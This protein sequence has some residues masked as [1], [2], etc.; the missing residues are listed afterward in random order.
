MRG[1]FRAEPKFLG[2][3]TSS[4]AMRFSVRIEVPGDVYQFECEVSVGQKQNP[5]RYFPVWMRGV[6]SVRTK[7]PCDISQFE[8]E[9]FVGQDQK[10]WQ[11]PPVEMRGAFR[12]EPKFLARFTSL[13]ARSYSVRTKIPGGVFQFMCDAFFGQDQNSWRYV[14][15]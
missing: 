2:I 9:V 3:F 6:F 15:V 8:R 4:N 7:I 12:S 14:P 11:F 5:W 1:V 10:S 13:N